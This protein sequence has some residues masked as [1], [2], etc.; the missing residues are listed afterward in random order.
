MHLTLQ[1]STP[2]YEKFININ[3]F[4]SINI[5]AQKV[6]KSPNEI[7][8]DLNTISISKCDIKESEKKKSKKS[9]QINVAVSSTRRS[10]KKRQISKRTGAGIAEIKTTSQNTTQKLVL[11]KEPTSKTNIAEINTKLSKKEYNNAAKFSNVDDIPLFNSCKN[12][13]KTRRSYCFN[14]NMINYI[15]EHFKYPKKTINSPTKGG[16]WVSFVIDKNGEVKNIKTLVHKY[17]DLLNKEAIR[18]VSKLPQFI[19]AKKDGKRIAVKYGFP[20]SLTLD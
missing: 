13:E 2:H 10:L 5:L 12:V 15:S 4:L 9:R 8:E 7:E 19:P 3:F 16:I 11:E 18:I 17:G 20:I 14:K 6:C 1:V